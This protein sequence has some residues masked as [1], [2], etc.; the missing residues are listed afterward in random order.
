LGT[1]LSTLSS[2]LTSGDLS[3]TQSAYAA[4]INEGTAAAQSIQLAEGILGTLN[5]NTVSSSIDRTTA[6]LQSVYARQSGLDVFA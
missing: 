3:T 4:Q 2:A 1:D 5:A 6:L